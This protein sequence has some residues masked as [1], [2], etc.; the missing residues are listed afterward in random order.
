MICGTGHRP[1]KLGNSWSIFSKNAKIVQR[2]TYEWLLMLLE[3]SDSLHVISGAALGFDT[4]LALATLK[5][6]QQG[7][8][9]TLEMAIPHVDFNNKWSQDD[10]DILSLITSV[11]DEITY[12][13]QNK[14]FSP[15]T[16]LEGRN[17]YMIRKSDIVI[18]L[19]DGSNGGTRNAFHFADRNNKP[20]IWIKPKDIL[21]MEELVNG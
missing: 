19:W 13:S 2:N 10:K 12:V 7:Y 3:N 9:I 18:A 15:T 16:D 8:N 21:S 5:L 4:H 17:R 11:S 14:V 20:I 6:K 1:D